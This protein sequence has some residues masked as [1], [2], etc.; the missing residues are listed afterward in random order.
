MRNFTLSLIALVLAAP[1]FAQSADMPQAHVELL[2]GWRTAEGHHM[3]ALHV[4]LEPGW[5]TYW[6]AP[7]EAG[8]PPGFDWSEARNVAAVDLHW[9]VPEVV[10]S[11][12][13]TTLGYH[14]ELVLPV[15]V[16]PTDP[17]AD[18][19]L[20]GRI[21][22]GICQNIC[23][24]IAVKVSA[25]LSQDM[26]TLDPRIEAALSMLPENAEEG[27]LLSTGCEVE[28]ISDG[29]RVTA[30][31]DLPAVGAGEVMVFEPADHTIWVSQA[32]E[33]RQGNLLV[34]SADLVPPT[35]QPFD[36]D[37]ETLRLTVIADG[38]AV[39]IQGCTR[40]E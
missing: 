24:P 29:V 7:G 28:P 30:K 22:M 9:P 25:T 17:N 21:E 38:R 26:T 11:N 34:A 20:A 14:S 31:L 35:A 15:E 3:A 4:V 36:F 23:I 1:G 12:G 6:R 16:T 5:K 19:S 18:I 32:E 8:I 39:D 33:T 10:T 40:R 37:T 2:P 13:M 27:G